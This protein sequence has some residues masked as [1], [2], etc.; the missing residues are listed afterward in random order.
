MARVVELHLNIIVDVEIAVVGH[1]DEK[2][3]A[4]TGV[5]LGVDR[6]QGG[7]P[8]A[9]AF[10]VEPYHIVLLNEA[11]VGQHD[12]AEVL[13]GVG[14]DHLT[15]EAELIEIRYQSAM[16]DVGMGDDDGVD[17]FRVDHDV[18]VGGVSLK[19]LALEHTAVQQYFLA[20]VGGDKVLASSYFLRCTD[21]FDF[22]IAILKFAPKLVKK[23][24]VAMFCHLTSDNLSNSG[25]IP[26]QSFSQ[27][28]HFQPQCASCR[29]PWPCQK[30]RYGLGRLRPWRCR[31][32][33]R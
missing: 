17:F 7:Q 9:A 8:L 25:V 19:A 12:V 10:L 11:A 13:C 21:E 3:H 23:S 20:V 30:G 32:S 22:H 1:G 2:L 14:A 27:L 26:P 5:L 31:R 16:V 18:S 6:L 33:V 15:A 29:C 4:G 24:E 28:D